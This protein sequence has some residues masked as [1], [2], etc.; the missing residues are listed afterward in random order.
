MSAKQGAHLWY[1]KGRDRWCINDSGKKQ[2]TPFRRGELAEAERALEAYIL[3][4]RKASGGPVTGSDKSQ[5]HVAEVVQYGLDIK[6]PKSARPVEYAQRAAYVLEYFGDMDMGQVKPSLLR[7]FAAEIGESFARRCLEDFRAAWNA[8]AHENEVEGQVRWWLPDKAEPR[9]DHLSFAD[10]CALGRVMRSTPGMR[11][12]HMIA[13]LAVGIGTMTRAS[14][15]YRASYFPE[16]GRPWIDLDTGTYHRSWSGERVAKNKKA[17]TV[18]IS[19]RLLR[20]LRREATDRIVGGKLKAGKR[21]V[22]EYAGRPADCRDAFKSAI[23]EARRR[24]PKLFRKPD[25]SP[26]LIVRHSLRHTG[27][28]WLSHAG[29]PALEIC[30]YSGMSMEVYSRVYAHATK[31]HADVLKHQSKKTKARKAETEKEDA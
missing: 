10:A 27:V 28:S 31:T 8:Y 5:V 20:W 13:F 30:E 24:Y 21:Y 14:R 25:G 19:P 18:P 17:P 2:R 16:P 22:V 1:E 4:K 26:K 7:E 12:S 23:E 6:G 15:I 9:A 11:W 29:V 3:S